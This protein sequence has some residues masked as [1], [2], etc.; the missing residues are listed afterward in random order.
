MKNDQHRHCQISLI[1]VWPPRW[2][3]GTGP[4]LLKPL[5]TGIGVLQ[6]IL[7]LDEAGDA[8]VLFVSNSALLTLI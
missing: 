7:N 1:S 8:T 2:I 4:Y 3:V 5:L 6:I